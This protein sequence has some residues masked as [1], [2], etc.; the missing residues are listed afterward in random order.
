MKKIHYSSEKEKASDLVDG[1]MLMDELNGLFDKNIKDL[2]DKKKELLKN[3]NSILFSLWDEISHN[4]RIQ[5]SIDTDYQND[6]DK[7][8]EQ[9]HI[10]KL[11]IDCEEWKHMDA[12]TPLELAKKEERL[13]EIQG[14]LESLYTGIHSLCCDQYKKGTEIIGYEPPQ[15]KREKQKKD[16]ETRN[17]KLQQVMD[18]LINE[19][20]ENGEVYTKKALVYEISKMEEFEAISDSVISKATRIRK[21]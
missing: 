7:K 20:K 12:A 1:R 18:N 15:L 8:K 2:P 19:K 10:F 21:D 11:T 9:E 14:E 5:A 3:K 13:K 17:K 6:P 4:K 16:T